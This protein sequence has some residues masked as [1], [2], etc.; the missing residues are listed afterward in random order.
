MVL[1]EES[2][3]V[4]RAFDGLLEALRGLGVETEPRDGSVSISWEG[5]ALTF[6]VETRRR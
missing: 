6:A 5:H 2:R 1:V 3:L 4:G